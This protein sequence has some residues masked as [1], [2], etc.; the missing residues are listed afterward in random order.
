MLQGFEITNFAQ[1]QPFMTT[2]AGSFGFLTTT[3]T[4]NGADGL[5]VMTRNSGLA[6]SDFTFD[7]VPGPITLDDTVQRFGGGND[8]IVIGSNQNT[9]Y[10]ADGN[11]IFTGTT[12]RSTLHGG[13]G[14]DNFNLDLSDDNA[15]V[16]GD[17]SDG[18]QFVRHR[19]GREPAGWRR[20]Q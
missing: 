9:I 8:P 3:I 4:L 2:V 14:S 19:R 13:T 10:G 5:T 16:G 20:R 11:D 1:L 15:L 12:A 17:D 6:A 18:D 7:I